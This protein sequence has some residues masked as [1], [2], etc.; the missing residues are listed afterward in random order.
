MI[1]LIDMGITDQELPL[2][3]RTT[4]A[5]ADAKFLVEGKTGKEI[6][7]LEDWE[8]EKRGKFLEC[9]LEMTAPIFERG[10]HYNL[11][12]PR[13]NLPFIAAPR[14]VSKGGYGEI[15]KREIHPSHHTFWICDK[16]S[17]SQPSPS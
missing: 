3:R 1:P 7:L 15:L 5:N 11:D 4:V 13:A 10:K 14:V 9:Q 17:V 6:P 16:Q 12:D 8:D 2:R